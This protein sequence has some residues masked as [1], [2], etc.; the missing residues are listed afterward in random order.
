MLRLVASG[1]A[2]GAVAVA[3]PLNRRA[4]L[5]DCLSS[6]SVPVSAP[7]T[8]DYE[9]DLAPFNVRTPYTPLVIAVPTTTQHI[10]DAIACGVEAGV[11]VTPK[12]GG[13]SYANYG[14]G[15]EDGHLVLELDRMSEVVLDT[16]TGV[17]TVQPGSRLGHVAV[18]LYEQGKRGISH[19]TCPG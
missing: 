15:G 1:L 3:G 10:Q 5:D 9:L 6:A 17:A 13:H 16:E 11:R 14:F 8:D 4:A 19:G 2:L 12:S 7:G 18:E